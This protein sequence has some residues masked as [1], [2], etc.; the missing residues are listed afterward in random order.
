LSRF[1][2]QDF[3]RQRQSIG[4]TVVYIPTPSPH[5][6]EATARGEAKPEHKFIKID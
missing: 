3:V 4:G 6:K 2:Y 1:G 5:G